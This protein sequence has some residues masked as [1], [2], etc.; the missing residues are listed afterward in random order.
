MAL[1]L[2]KSGI[3]PNPVTDQEE[4]YFTYSLYPH[5]GNLRDCDTVRESYRLNYPARSVLKGTFGSCESL[6]SIDKKNVM[7][8]T[9][10]AAED[11]DGMIIRVYE[12]ENTKSRASTKKTVSVLTSSLMR[13][14][15][16]RLY[17]VNTCKQRQR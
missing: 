15:L 6:F 16:S 13:L 2:I 10:K 17:S 5:E 8:E 9:V 14:R 3:E 12:Y 1:T 4:H 7:A 11:G